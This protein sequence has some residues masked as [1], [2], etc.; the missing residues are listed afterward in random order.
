MSWNHR[1]W[2]E[3]CDG[4]IENVMYSIRETFYNDAGEVCGVTESANTVDSDSVEGLKEM[5]EMMLKACDSGKEILD[6]DNFV[7][8]KWDDID[9]H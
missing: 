8:V 5:L 7:F 9:E 6:Y 2:K 1:V 3:N 4:N